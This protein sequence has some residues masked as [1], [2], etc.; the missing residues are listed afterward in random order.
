MITLRLLGGASIEG[1]DGEPWTGPAAQPRRLALLAVLAVEGGKAISRE[2]LVAL[3][4]PESTPDR[5]RHLLAD[6]LY[7]INRE[8][9]GDPVE[10]A[11]DGLRLNPA[12]VTS[13]VARF[14]KALSSGE[15]ERAVELYR[16]PF[17][18]GFFLRGSVEFDDWSRGERERL[19][20]LHREALVALAESTPI[21]ESAVEWWRRLVASDPYD[22]RW[23][24]G[25]ME[26]LARSGNRA[27]ALAEAR[28]HAALLAAEF[29]AEPDPTVEALAERIRE[30]SFA[31]GDAAAAGEDEIGEP[32]DD[33]AA[34]PDLE[35]SPGLYAEASEPVEERPPALPGPVDRLT[36]WL[37]SR[38]W[39]IG[40]AALV[41][42]ALIAAVAVRGLVRPDGATADEYGAIAVL[43][44]ENLSSDRDDRYFSDGMTED[45]ITRLSK[46][47]AFDV[48]S[49]TSVM[50]YENTDSSLREIARE[51]GVDAIVE[52][53]VRLVGDRV[54][55]TA[56]LVD[57]RTD[58]QLWAET[59]D[60]DLADVFAVQSDIAGRIAGAL[61]AT[62]EP[63]DRERLA[64]PPTE[65]LRAYEFY[66]KARQE[67]GEYTAVANERAITLFRRA[68]E[69]DPE[70]AEAWAGLADAYA[71]E[72]WRFTPEA[73]P[74]LTDSAMSAAERSIRIDPEIAEGHKARGLVLFMLGRVEEGLEA[75]RRAAELNRSYAPA[76]HNVGTILLYMGRLDETIPWLERAHELDPLNVNSLFNLGGVSRMLEDD[77]RAD[78]YFSR[79]EAMH[80]GH[81]LVVEGRIASEIV[82]GRTDRAMEIAGEIDLATAPPGLRSIVGEARLMA[83][84]LEG[85]RRALEPLEAFIQATGSGSP[86]GGPA[87]LALVLR[88][89]GEPARAADLL[90][91]LESDLESRLAG[92]DQTSLSRYRMSRV[93]ALQGEVDRA[94]ESFRRA[95]E[96]GYRDARWARRD[97]TLESLRGH[98]EFERALTELDALIQAMRQRMDEARES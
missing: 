76:V 83:G 69:L 19:E 80:P 67:Y 92:G 32:S 91:R 93:L 23:R 81:P 49:R 86:V 96:A 78:G 37:S 16:G 94:V 36:A 66:L 98:P 20:R 53:S 73:A 48:I 35:A 54:R 63:G 90:D 56:N 41:A 8:L 40:V 17:L 6:N 12:A 13:D 30:G 44:F 65:D 27:G 22:A 10:A 52:G 21:A 4:W 45:I 68:T 18:D 64:R 31:S 72:V 61:Q 57:P 51:L 77:V 46:L 50:R 5:A 79:V 29:D 70:F 84:D 26:V 75:T 7:V 33:P 25:L 47:G 89:S 85:A 39:G 34:G 88:R 15:P 97:P 95:V 24:T 28:S 60:R 58:T 62:L 1:P 14:E 43:P 11:G 2:R 74:A 9:D 42:L 38:G 59:Y 82:R 55:V 71:Q 87:T 3:L